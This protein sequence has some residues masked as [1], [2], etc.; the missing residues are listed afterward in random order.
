MTAVSSIATNATKNTGHDAHYNVEVLATNT[1]ALVADALS[2]SQ[3]D[4]DVLAGTVSDLTDLNDKT[5]WQS[6]AKLA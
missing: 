2:F 3:N 4:T 1:D 6:I 5:D